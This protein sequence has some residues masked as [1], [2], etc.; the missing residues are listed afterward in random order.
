MHFRARFL[1]VATGRERVFAAFIAV[2]VACIATGCA[3]HHGERYAYAPPYAPPVYP[4]PPLPAL[5]SAPPQVSVPGAATM[6]GAVPPG[7]VV[8]GAAAGVTTAEGVVVPAG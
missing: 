8:A 2:A 6:P 7:T 3:G 1:A 5:P 4:Q